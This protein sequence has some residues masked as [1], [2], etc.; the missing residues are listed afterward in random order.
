MDGLTGKANNL[1]ETSASTALHV[2]PPCRNTIPISWP[3]FRPQAYVICIPWVHIWPNNNSGRDFGQKNAELR[4]DTLKSLALRGRT[5]TTVT[6]TAAHRNQS[7]S[8]VSTP[9]CSASS[10]ASKEA[11]LFA[12]Q[13]ISRRPSQESM[14]M[15]ECSGAAACTTRG[16]T[17]GVLGEVR[18]GAWGVAFGARRSYQE[19]QAVHGWQR[20]LKHVQYAIPLARQQ[21]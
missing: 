11:T 17:R 15:E 7:P 14:A 3:K 6:N 5:D 21:C 12:S 16:C 2:K 19:R 10:K 20:G 13:S 1:A 9:F 8:W 18:L 4:V